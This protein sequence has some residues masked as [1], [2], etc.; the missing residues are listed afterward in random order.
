S[1]GRAPRGSRELRDRASGRVRG[2]ERRGSGTRSSY[3]R[4][5]LDQGESPPDGAAVGLVAPGSRIDGNRRRMA[6]AIGARF[7]YA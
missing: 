1:S 2:P 5:P 6:L 7:A 4:A 3:G